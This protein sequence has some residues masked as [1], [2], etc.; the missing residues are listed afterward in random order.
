MDISYY[1]FSK[2]DIVRTLNYGKEMTIQHLV[3]NG[4]LTEDQG[5]EYNCEYALIVIDNKNTLGDRIRKLFGFDDNSEKGSM[6]YRMVKI[7]GLIKTPRK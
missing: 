4:L 6:K 5:D 3:A 2:D 7:E 1:E